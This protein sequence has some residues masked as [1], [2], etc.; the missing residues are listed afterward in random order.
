MMF[1]FKINQLALPGE[2]LADQMVWWSA[3]KYLAALHILSL[4]LPGTL[5]P[6]LFQPVT[7]PA[8]VVVPQG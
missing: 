3:N 8:A 1:L 6:G 7:V 2:A 5:T 4:L